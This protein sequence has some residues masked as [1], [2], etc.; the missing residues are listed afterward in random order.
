[1]QQTTTIAAIL[2]VAY[3]LFL[4]LERLYPLRRPTRPL[5][6]RLPVN[7]AIS[8][9]AIATAAVLVR[10]VAEFML[11]WTDGRD[12]GLLHLAKL[13]AAVQLILAFLL[14]DL[15]FYYWHRANH[16]FALLWRFHN[17]HHIDPDL[18]VSTGFRFHAG[19]VALSTGFRVVQ[20]GLIGAPAWAFA[21][22]ELIFQ[23]ATLFEHSN[24]RLPLPL[25]RWLNRVLVTPRMHGIH[26]S[27]VRWETDSNYSVVLPWWDWLHRTL[28]LNVPQSRIRIGVPAYS[29]ATD[30][31][32]G[33]AL[34]LPLRRQRDY[35]R[36]SDGAPTVRNPEEIG[37]N[38]HRLE[39]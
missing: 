25:E 12:F 20:L 11:R 4:L 24:L 16:R 18:D 35:W 37:P 9:L 8:A 34:A 17:V 5:L 26:H 23:L 39:G 19:E 32:I 31:A 30:N 38:A 22:Y 28:R 3:G 21:I 2:A 13:P 15:S 27:Q 33:R 36:L 6:E 7:L 29:A 14:L 10:P 1:M